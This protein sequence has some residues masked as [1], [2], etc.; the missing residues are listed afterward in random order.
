VG[1]RKEM[2]DQDALVLG[3]GKKNVGK[4]KKKDPKWKTT[5]ADDGK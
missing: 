2:E 5:F 4:N 3:G 1:T